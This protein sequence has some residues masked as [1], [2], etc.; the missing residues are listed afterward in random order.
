M[1]SLFLSTIKMVLNAKIHAT[2]IVENTVIVGQNV[3]IGVL[4][5]KQE[6][7]LK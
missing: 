6:L 2:A 7:Y 3:E 1:V 5:Q 4:Q